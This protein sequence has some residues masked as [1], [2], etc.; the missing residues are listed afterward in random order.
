M[1]TN[2]RV[3]IFWLER[4]LACRRLL[5]RLQTKEPEKKL[6]PNVKKKKNSAGRKPVKGKQTLQ[7]DLEMKILIWQGWF[8]A[9]N[10]NR[11]A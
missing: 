4:E 7:P 6:R 1:L 8:P 2:V 11:N 10:R 5:D 3:L 9:R